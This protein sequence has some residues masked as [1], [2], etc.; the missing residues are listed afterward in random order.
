MNTSTN[1]PNPSSLPISDIFA[2]HDDELYLDEGRVEC[3]AGLNANLHLLTPWERQF[4][5]S[6]YARRTFTPRQRVQ[7][8]RLCITYPDTY[9]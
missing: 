2:Q 4:V 5:D 1:K 7:I 9:P 3:I 6:L 8:D